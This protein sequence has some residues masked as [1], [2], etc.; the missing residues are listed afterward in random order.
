MNA[1]RKAIKYLV[2]LGGSIL[3]VAL[4]V[5]LLIVF[6]TWNIF[7]ADKRTAKEALEP[8]CD[9]VYEK[10]D[11]DFKLKVKD[12]QNFGLYSVDLEIKG[13]FTD[14]FPDGTSID[15]CFMLLFLDF[16]EGYEKS[17]LAEKQFLSDISFT[18]KKEKCR[19]DIEALYPN[20]YG[21]PSLSTNCYFSPDLA[22]GLAKY[23][24][25]ILIS[26]DF[27]WTDEELE[28]IK[29]YLPEC[30]IKAAY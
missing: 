14:C 10:Y 6:T 30:E 4:F 13:N 29:M 21:A 3:S 20:N 2:V 16:L 23:K 17:G 5:F 19:F 1:K 28:I 18:Y 12:A 8:V 15:D 11:N 24:L 27:S 25:T 22:Q 26:K 9:F 7:G